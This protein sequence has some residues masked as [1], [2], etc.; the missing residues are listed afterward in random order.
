V[1][2]NQLG[3][4]IRG[5]RAPSRV[6]ISSEFLDLRDL[7]DPRVSSRPSTIR[8]PISAAL[9]TSAS[10]AENVHASQVE[11]PRGLQHVA[12]V[13]IDLLKAMLFGAG[14]V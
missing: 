4:E 5:D 10:L 9:S 1:I 6:R 13:R 11:M 7:A 14:Q 3:W 2:T 12:V 8:P